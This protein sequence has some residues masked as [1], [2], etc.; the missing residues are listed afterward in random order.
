MGGHPLTSVGCGF[1]FYMCI[2]EFHS[3]KA[4]PQRPPLTSEAPAEWML[5]SRVGP[6]VILSYSESPEGEL[7]SSSSYTLHWAMGHSVGLA[8]WLSLKELK[9][10]WEGFP[11]PRMLARKGQVTNTIRSARVLECLSN[12]LLPILIYCFIIS[13]RK[14]S[15][16]WETALGK[17][18]ILSTNSSSGTFHV[19]L[20]WGRKVWPEQAVG[21]NPLISGISTASGGSQKHLQRESVPSVWAGT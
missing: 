13:C 2:C 20:F 17:G 21:R 6:A 5:F 14:A 8:P 18:K 1:H 7:S 12:C 10:L 16:V 19:K 3:N 9:R 4:N 15:W 11:H